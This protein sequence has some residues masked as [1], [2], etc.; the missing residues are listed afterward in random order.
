[1]FKLTIRG[2]SLAEL[3]SNLA[4]MLASFGGPVAVSGPS[5]GSSPAAT[6]ASFCGFTPSTTASNVSSGS[7]VM[8]TTSSGTDLGRGL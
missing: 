8:N 4:D 6:S 5:I 1:M 7:A 3:K 2:D